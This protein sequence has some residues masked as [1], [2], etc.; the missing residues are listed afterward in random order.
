[1]ADT[2][3]RKQ[4]VFDFNADMKDLKMSADSINQVLKNL[5][6]RQKSLDS[7]IVMGIA[8][9]SEAFKLFRADLD[10]CKGSITSVSKVI[11]AMQKQGNPVSS[12][13]LASLK[14]LQGYFR[15]MEGDYAVVK[16]LSS[17]KFNLSLNTEDAES[18]FSKL[19]KYLEMFQSSFAEISKRAN[20]AYKSGDNTA[21]GHIRKDATT[22]NNKLQTLISEYNLFAS[23]VSSTGAIDGSR[24]AELGERFTNLQNSA[25]H[26]STSIATLN[27]RLKEKI[28][29]TPQEQS[30]TN[31]VGKIKTARTTLKEFKADFN[32][33][34]KTSDTQGIDKAVNGVKDLKELVKE[35]EKEMETL[36]A[37]GIDTS[38]IKAEIE[39]LKREIELT[40]ANFG[41]SMQRSLERRRSQMSSTIKGIM[42]SA[43]S[44]SKT[45]QTAIRTTFNYA[46][47]YTTQWI[48]FI[49]TSFNKVLNG[50]KTL[51]REVFSNNNIN[52]SGMKKQLDMLKSYLTIFTAIKASKGAI[53][54]SSDLIE[55]QNVVDTMFDN[56]A[57]D[58]E[59]FSARTSKAFGITELQAKSFTGIFGGML[60][61]SDINNDLAKELSKNLTAMGADVASLWNLDT[62]TSME[63]LQSGLSGLVQPLRELGI[64]M[65]IANLNAYALSKGID[66]SV[67]S[68]SASEKMLLRYAYIYEHLDVAQGDFLKTQLTWANQTRL[69]VNQ[70]Q[71]LGAVLGGLLVKVLQPIVVVLNKIIS[72]AIMA[73]TALSKMFHFAREDLEQQF[74]TG[75]KY[76]GLENLAED[77][78]D[79][80]DNLD[81]VAD[82]AK[83]ARQQLLGFDKLNNLTTPTDTSK[84]K[85]A[86]SVEDQLKNLISDMTYYQKIIDKSS[87]S[88]EEM[89]DTMKAFL[90]WI[91]YI[92]N[93]TAWK[94][95]TTSMKSLYTVGK[96]YFTLLNNKVIK[97]FLKWFG[98]SFVPAF[99][100]FVAEIGNALTMILEKLYPYF[101]EWLDSKFVKKAKEVGDKIVNF[102]TSTTEG[103]KKWRI[104]LGQAD[105]PFEYIK[106]SIDKAKQALYD[107]IG[108]Q[109][110]I[111]KLE[112]IAGHIKGI[113]NNITNG[114]VGKELGII[115]KALLSLATVSLDNILGFFEW[116][117]GDVK[118][119][120][121]ARK[122]VDTFGE[123]TTMTFTGIETFLSKLSSDSNATKLL[124]DIKKLVGDIIDYIVDNEEEIVTTIDKVVNFVDKLVGFLFDAQIGVDDLFTAF[125]VFKGIEVS[126]GLLGWIKEVKLGILALKGTT[127]TTSAE[128]V[129]SLGAVSA[130]VSNISLM[131]V[132]LA[133]AI[134]GL[135]AGAKAINT[136]FDQTDTITAYE[137]KVTQTKDALIQYMKT[138][139]KVDGIID[140][141]GA[142]KPWIAYGFAIQEA[143][144]ALNE[145]LPA[146]EFALNA[147]KYGDTTFGV[148]STKNILKYFSI[149]KEN[150]QAL[151]LDS[152]EAFK[153][154]D[155]QLERSKTK[156]NISV[157]EIRKNFGELLGE[158]EAV[159]TAFKEFSD[160][161]DDIQ[162]VASHFEVLSTTSKVATDTTSNGLDDVANSASTTANTVANSVEDMANKTSTATKGMTNDFDSVSDSVGELSDSINAQ[163]DKIRTEASNI[164]KNLV[165]G[166]ISGINANKPKLFSTVDSFS[167]SL[168]SRMRSNLKIKSPSRVTAEIGKFVDMGL[169]KGIDDNARLVNDSAESITENLV[170]SLKFD[171]SKLDL[172]PLFSN[173]EEIHDEPIFDFTNLPTQLETALRQVDNFTDKVKANLGNIQIDSVVSRSDN[174]RLTAEINA[175]TLTKSDLMDVIRSASQLETERPMYVSVDIA[176]RPLQ[177][178]IRNTINT[179]NIRSGNY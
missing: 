126:I 92:A 179:D 112:S 114:N 161:S 158:Y 152:T 144:E 7:E 46:K 142:E 168:V 40:G 45:M 166:V 21:L 22:A 147:L 30:M 57:S 135:V 105:N 39:R 167:N 68:M 153:A 107:F 5:E 172:E 28:P 95:F 47:R 53:N 23:T 133:G 164:G 87:E 41:A 134:P 69:L 173:I 2:E 175:Q 139:E 150:F 32:V 84:V 111:N 171:N 63:K 177:T 103:I 72:Q 130:S 115:L 27:T 52:Q 64:D 6:T 97:P 120:E 34:T 119:S 58:I 91:E 17:E 19:E 123:L 113:V 16:R 33:A 155:D 143:N 90:D 138:G 156:Q 73:S 14:S 29:P 94:K 77:S 127:A 11:K 157:D 122:L 128:M 88:Q 12:E 56:M 141:S 160:S 99:L 110:I 86:L 106:D 54:L 59:D 149:L 3:T 163:S 124:G 67:K 102:L 26:T 170:S 81:D 108:D 44:F 24:L 76:S 129:S 74:G 70:I 148:E 151:G 89:S 15:A 101:E 4:I 31:L 159:T 65:T 109:F 93:S 13:T 116:F 50:W 25:Q 165:N 121:F 78:E 146:S 20:E 79:T 117:T 96:K 42:T 132:G 51:L 83:K 80:A 174:A 48:R 140:I 36:G 1:M 37:N 18:D 38:H 145:V 62:K 162:Y 100:E 49:N 71:Q 82:S 35:L 9:D 176:G 85:D 8:K 136:Y 75:A 61:A 10:N 98:Y 55:V 104:G 137:N 118:V 43:S 125:F 131:L 178:F 60:K 154:M 66:K 169:A